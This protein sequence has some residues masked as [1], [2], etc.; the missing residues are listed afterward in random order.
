MKRTPEISVVMGVYNGEKELAESVESILTQRDADFEFII[1]NDGS[2]DRSAEML[3]EFAARDNRVR[4]IHQQNTGLTRA[5]VRGCGEARGEFI[6]RQD[7][8]D[9]SLPERLSLQAALLRDNADIAFVSSWADWIGPKG[10]LLFVQKVEDDAETATKNLLSDKQ[11]PAA[12]GSVMFRKKSYDAC[13]GYR[14]PFYFAQDVDLWLRLGY[15]GQ[16]SYV[17]QSLYQYRV[18]FSSIS[19]TRGG[20]QSEYDRLAHACH[21][22]RLAGEDEAEL[23]AE[24]T[25]LRSTKRPASASTE[26]GNP[27]YFIGRCLLAR[28]DKRASG[29]LWMA[30]RNNPWHGRAWTSLIQSKFSA[31]KRSRT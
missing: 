20:L 4:V 17:Q 13:G 26:T 15:V 28:G 14:P 30:I 22:V 31:G 12:H 8:D 5:L 1:V 16:L 6:A 29:Y 3:D 7:S 2:T 11:G 25:A 9:I 23:L 27:A 19:G 10:E 21:Q 24:A 18:S